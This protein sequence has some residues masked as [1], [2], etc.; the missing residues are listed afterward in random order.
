M[1]EFHSINPLTNKKS[2]TD[3]IPSGATTLA[4]MIMK[5]NSIF[6][7]APLIRASLSD[8]LIPYP[9]HLLG[10]SYPSAALANWV[11]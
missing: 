10:E 2:A 5:G 6:P 8:G 4:A 1:L 11:D 3:M 7:R 9:G